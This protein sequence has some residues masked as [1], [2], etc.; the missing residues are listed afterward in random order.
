MRA[1]GEIVQSC[2][3][4]FSRFMKWENSSKFFFIIIK[5]ALLNGDRVWTYYGYLA[6]PKVSLQSTVILSNF[7]PIWNWYDLIHTQGGWH[8]HGNLLSISYLYAGMRLFIVLFLNIFC[9]FEKFQTNTWRQKAILSFSLRQH[10]GLV[11]TFTSISFQFYH[12]NNRVINKKPETN[13]HKKKWGW[14]A[15]SSKWLTSSNW[16]SKRK[17][18]EA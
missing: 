2:I 7:S 16:L 6:H 12:F 1:R 4:Q 13:N 15:K 10:G 17:K 11:Y 8:I 18:S 5:A 9:S 3:L 14:N